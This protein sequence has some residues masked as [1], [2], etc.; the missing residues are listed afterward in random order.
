MSSATTTDVRKGLYG[1]I[2]DYTAVSKVMPETNSLTYRGY[3]VEDLVENCSFEEVFYLLWHGE[4]PTAQQLAEFN[5]RGRSYRSLDAGLISLIHSLP[6]EAHPMDVMRTAVS[7][8]GTKDSEYFT[9]DSEHIRKVGHTLLA[10][11]PM[12]LAMDI[13][14]RKGLD[15]IAPDSSKSV[16]ENLLSMVFGTGPESPA[17]NPADVRDFEKSLILYAEHSF[18]ASTFTAR[19]IT[20]TK[21]DV[22]SAITGAIGALKGPLHG[23][24]NEFVM[25][26]MLAIDDPNKAADW[27]NNALDNK[28][29]VMGFGHRVY[30]RGDSRVP[31]MEKSFRELAARHDGEKWVAMY[32]NMR[33]AMD[34]RTG[35]KPNL[36]FPAGPAYHLLGFP[37][38]FFTPLFVIA[39]V[40]GWTAH[41]VEQYE[42]NSLIRPLSE[43]NGEEQR[44]VAPI[45]KR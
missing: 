17:S 33:D 1:V 23:G 45:E 22:Y 43:Y 10:Q 25:H 28:N 44:E 38:D 9:T 29:V 18:N 2:A 26:T 24:A 40:A 3:A 4:L 41:I 36:D 6:K 30:K 35:I 27:I 8:M 7:Y 16:A 31:S 15:I 11:L 19:V 39:R 32:E 13:R 20:S 5:E 34:A 21:S 14:R 37:V 12:V 42:N